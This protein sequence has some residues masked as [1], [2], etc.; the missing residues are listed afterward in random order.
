MNDVLMLNGSGL[1]LE[2]L[3]DV[4]Y[5]GRKVRIDPAVIPG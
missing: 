4:V 3:Y 2:D 1:T 5:H